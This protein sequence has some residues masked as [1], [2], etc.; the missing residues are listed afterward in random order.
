ML[1]ERGHRREDI[2]NYTRWYV[3]RVIMHPRKKNGSLDVE[4]VQPS[5]AEPIEAL[6]EKKL[7]RQ[8]FPRHLIAERTVEWIELKKKIEAS[9]QREVDSNGRPISRRGSRPARAASEC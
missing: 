6:I 5:E 4:A 3:K 8:K 9:W 1:E 2:K 7:K